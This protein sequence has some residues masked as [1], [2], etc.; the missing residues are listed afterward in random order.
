M[1]FIELTFEG[2]KYLENVA[3]IESFWRDGENCKVIYKNQVEIT[4]GESYEE[5][6]RLLGH[7]GLFKYHENYNVP[8]SYDDLLDKK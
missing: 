4:V 6:K 8:L 1:Q 5:V 3:E 7:A 2:E